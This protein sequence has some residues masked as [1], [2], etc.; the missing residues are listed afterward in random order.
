MLD[1]ATQCRKRAAT[2]EKPVRNTLTPSVRNPQKHQANSHI[3]HAEAPVKTC[4]GLVLV[5]SVSVSQCEPYSLIVGPR[6]GEK[7]HCRL[8]KKKPCHQSSYRFHI[9]KSFLLGQWWHRACGS[10]KPMFTLN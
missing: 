7:K 4:A 8:W 5:T 10:V 3:I 9:L 6:S 2:G 1:K